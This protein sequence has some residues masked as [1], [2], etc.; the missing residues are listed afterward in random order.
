MKEADTAYLSVKLDYD[1]G[2]KI[3]DVE[4]YAGSTEYDYEI[5]AAT[6]TIRSKDFDAEG[7]TRPADSSSSGTSGVITEAKAQ[8]IALAKVPGATADHI[9][10]HLDEDDGHFLYEGTIF[11][12]SMEY[13]FEI[14]AYSGAILEWDAESIYD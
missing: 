11:Y 3:Y 8:E 2:A 5:D 13:E 1:D 12:D 6:G 14:D 7:Y 9:R 4:F 10:L